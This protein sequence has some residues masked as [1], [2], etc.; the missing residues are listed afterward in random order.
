VPSRF[1]NQL[2]R[3]LRAHQI[4]DAQPLLVAVSGGADSIALLRALSEWRPTRL[5]AVYVDHQLRP[6]AEA[7]HHFV[8]ETAGR[9]GADFTRVEVESK[10]LQAE[11][12][13]GV[14]EAA[15]VGRYQA[16][17]QLA[18]ERQ[19]E[20]VV[21]GH[22]ANDQAETV[23]WRLLRGGV[24]ASLAGMKE[25]RALGQGVSLLRPML[26]V[27]RSV[28]LGYL[29]RLRQ[30]FLEDASNTSMEF[31]RNRLRH[32]VMPLLQR[33]NPSVVDALGALAIEAQQVEACIQDLVQDAR[34]RVIREHRANRVVLSVR[35]MLAEKPAI[36]ARLLREL[37]PGRYLSRGQIQSLLRLL[38]SEGGKSICVEGILATRQKDQLVLQWE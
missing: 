29:H 38:E 14:E 4:K 31:T 1:S 8:K 37:P 5:L 16:L 24:L 27:E 32:L 20:V 18:T 7:E 6:E 33:E 26:G 23:L 13:L 35:A 3:V 21:T 34:I 11:R 28:L 12:R 9:L 17:L 10:Q 30:G 15:R 25:Q 2:R 19:L 22:T 36:Q